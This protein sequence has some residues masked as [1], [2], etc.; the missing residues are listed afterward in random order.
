MNIYDIKAEGRQGKL[1]GDKSLSN[2]GW[3]MAQKKR[4]RWPKLTICEKDVETHFSGS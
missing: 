4:R 2:D 1:K 3:R